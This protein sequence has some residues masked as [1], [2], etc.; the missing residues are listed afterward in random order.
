M[1]K[2]TV[3]LLAIFTFTS[4]F[5]IV[6]AATSEVTWDNYEK[7][8]DI[9]PSNE[10]RKH[11]RERTFKNFEKHFSKLAAKLPEGQVLK[12]KVSDVDLAGDT[13]SGGI[14][15]VR[16]IKDIFI[17]RINFSFELLNTDKRI[18]KSGDIVLKDMG[19]MMNTH[20]KYRNQ[21]LGYE[22]A[23]LDKWFADTFKSLIIK[24]K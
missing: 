12:I 14:N 11:F 17:P 18:V 15:Q 3:T 22:K 13:H 1:K 8:R 2:I 23:M 4:F 21:A 7:Y 16:I 9:H 10:S 19:F 5:Q 6:Y 24:A 20:L